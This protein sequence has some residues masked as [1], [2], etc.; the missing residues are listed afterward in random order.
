MDTEQQRRWREADAALDRLLDL[1]PEQRAGALAALSEDIRQLTAQLLAAHERQGVLDQALPPLS[2]SPTAEAMLNL[3]GVPERIGA[4]TLGEVLG[5]GG[6][7]IV[8]AARRELPAGTQQAAM[9]LLTVAALAADGRRR[10]L[11]EHQVLARL[12]HPRIAALLDAGVLEDG[13]PYLAMQRVDGERIDAW[14]RRQ[15]LHPRAIVTLFLQVCD[16]VAY[17]HRQLVVHR[18]LKPGNILVDR[19]GT[20]RLLDFGI[21][22]LLDESVDAESTRTEFRALTPQ[23]AA[24]EQFSGEDSGTAADV[25]GLGAVLYHL[26]T[27]RPPRMPQQGHDTQITQP[28]RAVHSTEALP[29]PARALFSRVLKGDLDAVLLKALQ[30][31][32]VDRYPDAASLADDLRRWLQERPVS[33]ARAGGGYRARKFIARHRGGVAASLLLAAAIV[34]GVIGTLWQAQRAEHAAEQARREAVRATAVSEFL[35]SLF[36]AVSPSERGGIPD[37]LEVLEVGSQQARAAVADGR[38]WL[39]AEVLAV[40]GIAR[41]NVSDYQGAIADLQL[42]TE[43]YDAEPPDDPRQRADALRFLS[44]AWRNVGPVQR[45]VAPGER[46]VALLEGVAGAEGQQVAARISLA[47]ALRDEGSQPQRTEQILRTALAQ[48]AEPPLRNTQVHLDAL[49]SLS[50]LLAVTERSGAEQVPLQEQR[51]AIVRELHG[52][53]SGWHA[54]TLADAVPTFRATRQYQR[55]EELALEAIAV[56]SRVYHQPHM[57]PAVARCNYAALLLETARYDEA[58][59]HYEAALAMDRATNRTD[60]HAESCVHGLG[61]T[62]LRAGRPEAALQQFS[63]RRALMAARGD[64][65]SMFQVSGCSY[66]AIAGLRTGRPAATVEA[67]LDR[68]L[69]PADAAEIRSEPWVALARA[70][71]ALARGDLASAGARIEEATALAPAGDGDHDRPRLHAAMLA[72]DRER[73]LGDASAQAQAAARLRALQ[74]QPG[75]PPGLAD[76]AAAC[77]A[78]TDPLACRA[79]P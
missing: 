22:R 45:A 55:A 20:V 28:S 70:E 60:R 43:L 46:A 69:A 79:S 53:D 34:A 68:C 54:F 3:P 7:S 75:L 8:Y 61:L 19:E 37:L 32:P 21:A 10:F 56:A 9:K 12:T 17:A 50:T 29:P 64:Q 51:I 77:L 62:H 40:T 18:D 66:E 63:A 78:G 42:A 48:A 39:A 27:G 49:N 57:I 71:L 5:R 44:V 25:F 23:Y 31:D 73:A 4:W 6:M 13:T 72:L 2:G 65:A 74:A 38:P 58:V 67:G 35:R 1:P 52:V 11:R 76:G 16:T 30:A 15:A 47:N 59:G 33:A 24:P 41:A 14:C 36:L 26:L